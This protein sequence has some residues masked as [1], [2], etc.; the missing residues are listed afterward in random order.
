MARSTRWFLG[1]LLVAG[2][3]L[4]ACKK[5]APAPTA[6]GETAA[7]ATETASPPEA[8]LVVYS[9]RGAV[10]VEPL[11]ARFTE[12]TG[13]AVDLRFDKSTEALANR[14]ATE[15]AETP[16]D[17]FFA[18]DS[19]YLGVLGKAGLL[20]KLPLEIIGMV[21]PLYA[22]L[23]GHWVGISGRARV[24]V[25][26]PTKFKPDDLPN[27]L[28]DLPD[29]ALKGRFGWAPANASFQAHISALRH[30]WGEEMTRSWLT[31]MK[32]LEPRVYPKNSPQVKAVSKGEID[33][34][35]VNHY[36]LH[37]LKAS[38]PDLVAANFTFPNAQDGGNLLMVSGAAITA[39]SKRPA[40]AQK[41]LSFL[42][43]P[44]AQ[45]YFAQEVFE[46]PTRPD[47]ERHPSVPALGAMAAR[48]DQRHL[49]DVAPTLALLRELGL[50]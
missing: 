2:L 43:S 22:D 3:A 19:G 32:A 33:V 47:V 23:E 42:V 16:A 27:S 18:Q 8:R 28:M 5:D 15:G 31:R 6:S 45:G 30:L 10:L 14:L 4:V 17:V 7:A 48:V 40:L 11:M 21:D 24:L 38:N 29:M 34:G 35:W 39:A 13:V 25:Y 20:A 46:Y 36:Y 9:G 1:S 41:L 44:E 37:K 26:N 49:S 12:Q 50:Q